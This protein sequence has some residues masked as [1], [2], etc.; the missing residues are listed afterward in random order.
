M[1]GSSRRR[2]PS[3][4][5]ALGAIA[6]L[7]TCDL[8]K[9]TSPSGAGLQSTASRIQ[10]SGDT[11]LI[12]GESTDLTVESDV[13]LGY[14][15]KRWWSENTAVAAVDSLS[16]TITGLTAGSSLIRLRLLAPELDTGI[17]KSWAVR[18]RFGGI[19][20]AAIDSITGLGLARAVTVTGTGAGGTPAGVADPSTTTLSVHDSGGT[21]ATVATVNASRQVVAKKNGTAYLVATHEGMR[22]STRFR[23]RQVAKTMLYQV[24]EFVVNALNVDRST[25]LTV[26]D[27]NDSV[28]VSPATR[29]SV[30]DTLIAAINPAT[31]VLRSRRVD[32]TRIFAT[33]DTVTTSQR[34]RIRQVVASLTK[35]AG[36]NQQDTIGRA[37]PVAP[38]V[39]ARDSG[40]T[41]VAGG[42]VTFSVTQGGGTISATPATT[43]TLGV[44]TGGQWT[45]GLTAGEQRVRAAAGADTVTFVATGVPMRPYKLSFLTQPSTRP[46][47][48]A[49]TPNVRVA[50]QDSVGNVSTTSTD[51]VTISLDANPRNATLG[52]TRKVAA[53][54]GIATFAG[55]SV[56]SAGIDYRLSAA[57][58]S[59]QGTSSAFFAATGPAH[60]MTKTAGDGQLGQVSKPLAIA[61][62]VTI[63]DSFGTGVSGVAVT[64]TPG[65]SSGT[66][67]AGPVVT[68]DSGVARV[69]WTLGTLPGAQTLAASAGSL[70]ATFNATAT[71]SQGVMA[72][73]G[74]G[75]EHSCRLTG[76]GS[77]EC[78]GSGNSGQLGHGAFERS[79]ARVTVSGGLSFFGL[80]VGEWHTCGLA[81][82]GAVY[83][84]GANGLGEGGD[85]TLT[86]KSSP[87]RVSGS[88]VFAMISAGHQHSC[89]VTAAG[90]AYCWGANSFGQLGDGTTT[91]RSVPTAVTGGHTFQSVFALY[92]H[93]CGI[94]TASRVYCWGRNDSGQLGDASLS[95]RLAPVPVSGA[96]L[97]F[98][99]LAGGSGHTCGITDTNA[100]Y[101]WGNN[102]AGQL[103]SGN[104]TNRSTP[105]AI[106]GSASLKAIT[107]GYDYVC[108]LT[109]DDTPYCWGLNDQGQLGDGTTTNRTTPTQIGGTLKFKTIAAG[110]SAHTCATTA[111]GAAYC[112]GLN[113]YG[114]VGDGTIGYSPTP[115]A[116][117]GAINFQSI[118]S[119]EAYA[120]GLTPSGVA[121]CW[122]TNQDGR[123]GDGSGNEQSHPVAVDAAVQFSSI[124]A[125]YY[126]TTCGIAANGQAYCWGTNYYGHTGDG[127]LVSP[128]VRPVAVAGGQIYQAI[129]VGAHHTCGINSAG[130]AYCWG[131]NY[132]GQLG[133]NTTANRSAPTLVSSTLAFKAIS[134]GIQHSCAVTTAGLA[135]CWGSNQ[136]GQLGDGT[137]TDRS[138]P[139]AVG[140]GL[141]FA[142]I[143]AGAEH[144]CGVTT[145]N[146]VYC[147]GA[148]WEGRIGDGT[149]GGGAHR[150]T[151]TRLAG[152]ALVAQ[153]VVAGGQ[154]TC[155]LSTTGAAYCWGSNYHGELGDG[156]TSDR[157][158]PI[159]VAGGHTFKALTGGGWDGPVCGV[160]TAGAAYCWGSNRNGGLGRGT[161]ATRA[162]PV[163]VTGT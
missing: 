115:G 14:V 79:T 145:G 36:D 3:A 161:T 62:T 56:D 60:S 70:N 120:C 121:Y 31:G 15:A 18:V 73:I 152:I 112:W 58:G 104:N 76:A 111:E 134:S 51:S 43:D 154:S 41:L 16:G 146:V 84:W 38:R 89:G 39:V 125:G 7:A 45:L 59:L 97:N 61:A 46:A 28:M 88:Q 98:V 75:R 159:A 34:V 136:F 163:R 20:V 35:T 99:A 129:S 117:V 149:S 6:L 26:K 10:L 110:N 55:I 52:G 100:G 94:T 21:G 109:T 106:T 1:R 156:T 63:K 124:S 114:E 33:V 64:F 13:D 4:A 101:C 113:M 138:A 54:Q 151:P 27:V 132:K 126:S 68:N 93:T 71:L 47:R 148:N 139:V 22:D 44:A 92:N 11:V 135:Y 158:A 53:V 130:T 69:V 42:S 82:G 37:L 67:P 131:E 12:V 147:W 119:G 78:W 8:Q 9:L 91:S 142:T 50:V 19:R 48:A 25:T 102:W 103:G 29:W 108:A 32:T 141:T 153:S 86:T 24:S 162:T 85:G 77:I 150:S 5:F 57:S 123:L 105:G 72:P 65:A 143:S 30:R 17:V 87:S 74:V 49:I 116:V 96:A 83:C 81:S 23:V 160:T 128:R 80:A 95:D 66:V 118:E 137:N 40:N 107:S 140:G 2:L 127:T 144:T 157:T 122:G 155:A 90:A 133:D